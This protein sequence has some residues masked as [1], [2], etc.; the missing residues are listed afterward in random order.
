MGFYEPC[1]LGDQRCKAIETVGE[2]VALVI[3][4]VDYG[5]YE[6]KIFIQGVKFTEQGCRNEQVQEVITRGLDIK[7]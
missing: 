2:S 7:V 6:P 3:H 1:K 5:G 4:Q